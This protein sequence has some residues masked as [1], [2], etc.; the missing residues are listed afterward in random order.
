MDASD[1][2]RRTMCTPNSSFS[3]EE[4]DSDTDQDVRLTTGLY[5]AFV[6]AREC[7]VRHLAFKTYLDLIPLTS[8][9][10]PAI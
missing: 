6:Y 9:P 1:V 5:G 3:G 2:I 7:R 8:A 10:V 4:E